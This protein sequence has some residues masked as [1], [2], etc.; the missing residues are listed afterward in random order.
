[1]CDRLM[2]LHC[3]CDTHIVLCMYNIHIHYM[4]MSLWDECALICKAIIQAVKYKIFD[5]R[6]K[7]DIHL[8]VRVANI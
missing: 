4:Y 5:G 7:V 6:R 2:Q 1:M 3:V 8:Y